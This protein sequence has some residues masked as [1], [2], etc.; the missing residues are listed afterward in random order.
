LFR[1]FG[2]VVAG[3]VIISSFVALTMTPMLS[4]KLL[5]KRDKHTWFYNK[6]EPFYLWLNDLYTRALTTFM[7]VRWVSFII[8][9]G[10]VLGIYSMYSVIPTELAPV[11]DRGEIR[12]SVTGPEGATFEYMERVID[13]LD[14]ELAEAIP[15]FERVGF[16]SMASPGFGSASTNSGF[17]RVIL[18]DAIQRERSQQEIF[19]QISVILKNKTSVRAYASQAQSIG[20]RRGGLPVQYVI[21]A[22]TLDKLKDVIPTF[23]DAANQ[24]PFFD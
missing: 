16:I 13:E 23:M 4:S 9:G 11:E 14:A 7:K 24:S 5:K 2:I 3:S 15:E 17:I 12:I 19:E 22:Q 10:M 1:E 20:D 8:I 18:K 21:Q 6:T